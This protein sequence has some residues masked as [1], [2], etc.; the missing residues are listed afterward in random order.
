MDAVC[1]DGYLPGLDCGDLEPLARSRSNTWPRLP[2]AP[3]VPVDDV[4]RISE[5]AVMGAYP[6]VDS[7]PPLQLLPAQH[8]AT[9]RL[10][11]P[12]PRSSPRKR[13]AWGNSSYAD[14]ITQA[15]SSSPQQRMTL[16]E[17][18]KWMEENVAHFR[19]V[20]GGGTS[21]SVG[22]K[23]SIRHNLSL[24]DR[25]VRVHNE[26]K[27][28]SSWWMVNPDAKAGGRA[29][30]AR[31][32]ATMETSK[33]SEDRRGRVLRNVQA[34]RKAKEAVGT[35]ASPPTL[36]GLE[37]LPGLPCGGFRSRASSTA[38]SYASSYGRLSPIPSEEQ[39]EWSP[40]FP[41]E[42]LA[43]NLGD[44]MK[45]DPGADSGC[46]P[47]RQPQQSYR[48]PQNGLPTCPAG[49]HTEVG[50]PCAYLPAPQ[51]AVP[52]QP[53]SRQQYAYI[54][55]QYLPTVLHPP[56]LHIEYVSSQPGLTP[57]PECSVRAS[58]QDR[59]CQQ[60]VRQPTA[61]HAS[62]DTR[63]HQRVSDH[64]FV[65]HAARMPPMQQPPCGGQ[66]ATDQRAPP[67]P[68]QRAP[69]FD[70]LNVSVESGLHC[71]V[72]EVVRQELI[73]EGSLD[74]N[75]SQPLQLHAGAG[76]GAGPSVPTYTTLV[77]SGR[78]LVR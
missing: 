9:A 21:S 16:A 8:P 31:R 60:S 51:Q 42:L 66:R 24:L 29:R 2:R 58:Q 10:S 44:Y 67:A 23:N 50:C 34:L 54:D 62:Y 43:N 14:L 56:G 74:F 78:F 26:D 6:G 70:D 22:W 27:G 61:Y 25:F 20:E 19:S 71:N 32:R 57:Q 4:I 68:C 63:V 5:G 55:E 72:E 48:D 1:R 36:S 53:T 41:A 49:V 37:G 75:F 30:S 64:Q 33:L 45:L 13:N 73:L 69:S 46:Y 38:S 18:Y 28:K 47:R 40:Y 39:D 12:A 3:D 11:D 76:P 59:S 77:T 17:I 52:S 15:I 65:D 7:S 35:D